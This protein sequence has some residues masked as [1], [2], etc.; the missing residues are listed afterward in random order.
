MARIREVISQARQQL[1]DLTDMTFG[2]RRANL[3]NLITDGE[4]E[5]AKSQEALTGIEREARFAGVRVRQSR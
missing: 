1:S 3:Q 4:A 5:L 2:T